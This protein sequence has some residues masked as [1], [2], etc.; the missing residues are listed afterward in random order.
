MIK[1]F[2]FIY[3]FFVKSLKFPHA[4]IHTLFVMP[5]VKIGKGVILR[6]K[7]KVQRGVS[8]GDY[9]FI[10]ENSQIDSNT[11]SIGSYCSISHGVKIG[12]GPHPLNFFSTSPIFYEPY[13]GFIDELRYD[14]FHD[15]GFTEI[16]HDVL[17]GANAII[18][19]G[20]KVGTG[21][22]IGAGAVVNKDVAPYS[23]VAGIPAK[24]IRFRFDEQTINGLLNSKWW[25][26]TP[27]YLNQV[28]SQNINEFLIN[29]NKYDQD[30]KK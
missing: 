14:E 8:I 7:V 21:S 23:I 29:L 24:H 3:F 2:Y 15:K 19:A 11:K 4:K 13:R 27:S 16:G 5:N 17:I 25:E 9:T 10:N 28:F 1:V 6:S 12:L 18:L 22:V 26:F 20:V 30:N